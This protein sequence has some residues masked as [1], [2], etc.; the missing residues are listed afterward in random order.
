[1]WR[2][3]PRY[4]KDYSEILQQIYK[5]T[6]YLYDAQVADELLKNY[7]DFRFDFSK[8]TGRLRYIYEGNELLVSIIPNNGFIIPSLFAAERIRKIAKSPKYRIIVEDDAAK[9]A[10][11]SKS[12]FTHHVIGF[13]PNLLPN[14]EVLVVDKQ[15]KLAA[16]GKLNVPV[17][18]ITKERNGVA[19]KVKKGNKN[20]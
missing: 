14:C 15:D 3:N 20:Y 5:I 2:Q 17:H 10:S 9:Y 12:V 16:I 13:D 19:V 1:M 6:E 7:Q 11:E 4:Q 8:Q 18:F